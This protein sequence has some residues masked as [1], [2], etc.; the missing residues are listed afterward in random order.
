MPP[1]DREAA[2][3]YQA[4]YRLGYRSPR[5]SRPLAVR[6]LSRTDREHGQP[7][8]PGLGRCW[9]WTGAVNPGGYGVVKV[10]GRTVLVHRVSLELALGRPLANGMYSCHKCDNR[11]CLRPRHLYE[12][13]PEDNARDCVDRGRHRGFETRPTF[14]EQ[15]LA[16]GAA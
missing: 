9:E 15:L 12:G 11:R 5:R 10:A 16:E 3:A 13:T 6:L 4:A 1:K 14:L 2:R 7:N 8:G